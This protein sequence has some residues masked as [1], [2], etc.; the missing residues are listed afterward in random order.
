MQTINVPILVIGKPTANGNVYTREAVENAVAKLSNL[1]LPVVIA[2]AFTEF[3]E[4]WAVKHAVGDA[5]NIHIDK[6]Q[7]F[8]NVRVEHIPERCHAM[9]TF[10]AMGRARISEDKVVDEYEITGVAVGAL[11][12]DPGTLSCG[13]IDS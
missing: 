2:E 12:N 13:Q 9:L 4:E 7:V 10:G 8:A 1:K 3:G 5:T 6:D 11:T